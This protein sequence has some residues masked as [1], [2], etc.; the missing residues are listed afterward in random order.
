MEIIEKMKQAG[1]I[2][3]G[4]ASGSGY[5]QDLIAQCRFKNEGGTAAVLVPDQ[6]GMY[7]MIARLEGKE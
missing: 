2:C 3:Y 4:Y 5:V 1:W 7:L 6:G